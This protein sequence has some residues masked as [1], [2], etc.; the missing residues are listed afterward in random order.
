MGTTVVF[1]GTHLTTDL[2]IDTQNTVS[3]RGYPNVIPLSKR[4]S[5]VF[6]VSKKYHGTKEQQNATLCSTRIGI[7]LAQ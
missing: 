3:Y 5:I 7:V 4:L 6:A 2:D 1:H